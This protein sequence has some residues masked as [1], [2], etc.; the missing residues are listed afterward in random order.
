L[1]LFDLKIL[2]VVILCI[3]IILLGIKLAGS[4]TDA[5]VAGKKKSSRRKKQ[6]SDD[7]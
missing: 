1:G 5:A 6:E 2:L 3:P 4:L 7:R